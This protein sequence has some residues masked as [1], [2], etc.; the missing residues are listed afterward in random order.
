MKTACP[1]CGVMGEIP[2]H[3]AA[4]AKPVRCR[5]CGTRFY[6]QTPLPA[7][8]PPVLEPIDEIRL[9]IEPEPLRDR[10][11]RSRTQLSTAVFA[12]FTLGLLIVMIAVIYMNLPSNNPKG[13]A[14]RPVTIPIGF[15]LNSGLQIIAALIFLALSLSFYFIPTLVASHRHH[16]NLLAIGVLNFFLGWIGIGWI[17]A[18]VWACTAVQKRSESQ[19][20][21]DD[22]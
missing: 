13:E 19:Y 12:G 10:K 3:L 16:H 20:L 7:T 6:P 8:S 5:Q 21:D 2:D 4:T 9:S 17:I 22:D 1:F 18:L 15:D 14:A 11:P